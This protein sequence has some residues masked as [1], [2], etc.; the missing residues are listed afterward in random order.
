MNELFRVHYL[1]GYKVDVYGYDEK[2]EQIIYCADGYKER[3]AKKHYVCPFGGNPYPGTLIEY[4]NVILPDGR[5][6]RIEIRA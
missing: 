6:A 5:H 4:Y 2:T 1:N 3:K